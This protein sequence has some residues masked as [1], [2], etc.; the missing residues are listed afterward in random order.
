MRP[1]KGVWGGSGWIESDILKCTLECM[2][3]YLGLYV[4]SKEAIEIFG[5]CSN[6]LFLCKKQTKHQ[7]Q[8][9]TTNKPPHFNLSSLE[10][11]QH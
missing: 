10:Q 5:I 9:T 11:W 2:K 3:V 7:K 6:Y 4:L 8:T 1:S